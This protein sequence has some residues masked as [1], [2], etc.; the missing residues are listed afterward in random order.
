MNDSSYAEITEA[1]TEKN[2][3]KERPRTE[4]NFNTSLTSFRRTELRK[5]LK[6]THKIAENFLTTD[7][8][9]SKQVL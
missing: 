7:F 3:C 5:L 9:P 1:Q 8:Y 2:Q 4:L 6:L